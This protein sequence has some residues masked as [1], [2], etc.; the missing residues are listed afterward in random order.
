MLL[1]SRKRARGAKSA[2]DD[3][4]DEDVEEQVD[5]GK[6]HAG[7]S[8]RKAQIRAV[9]ERLK[10]AERQ[11]GMHAERALAEAREQG[12]EEAF[13][14]DQ[15]FEE[16]SSTA[17][18]KK[19]DE[20]E[21]ELNQEPKQSLYIGRL[22][23]TA[24]QR[25][26]QREIAFEK[27]KRREREAEIEGTVGVS[28][29]SEVFVT[30]AYKKRL[31]ERAEFEQSEQAREAEESKRAG[32]GMGG[33]YSNLMGSMMISTAQSAPEKP[34]QAPASAESAMES[35]SVPVATETVAI[36]KVARTRKAESASEPTPSESEPRPRVAPR[37]LLSPGYLDS[38][39]KRAIQRAT[40]RGARFIRRFI[41]TQA[42]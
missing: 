13:Q 6:K 23:E 38:A 24:R 2:L 12:M 21:T 7:V 27:A 40:N 20:Q 11:A 31:E 5:Q 26:L 25:D 36:A 19:K 30:S 16:F 1:K 41:S 22:L 8:A 15:G 9:N 42:I 34:T 29:S 32:Q 28:S 14:Y 4:D 17:K 35:F 37:S 10:L 39:R 33:F 18:Q 3:G